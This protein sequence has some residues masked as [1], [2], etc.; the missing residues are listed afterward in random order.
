MAFSFALLVEG[1]LVALLVIADASSSLVS[2]DE[3]PPREIPI[4]VT[5]VIE[6]MPLLKLG[7]KKRENALP[8]MWRK[9]TPKKRYE[10]KSAASTKAAKE[11][12][13]LPESEMARSDES[14]APED[15]E[16]AKKVDEDIIEEEPTEDPNYAEEG[17][18]DGVIGGTETDALK[19]FVIDQYK[20]T[21]IAWFKAGFSAPAG[22]EYCELV[23]AASATVAADRTVTSFAIRAGSGNE[24]LDAKAKAHLQS[25]VGKKLPPPP[26]QYPELGEFIYFPRISGKNSSCNNKS[27]KKDK[28]ATEPSAPDESPDEA[29]APREPSP[30][31]PDFGSDSDGIL[32]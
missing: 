28:V 8:D 4:A 30:A 14:P 32:E 12:D 15:A 5:P 17:E 23:V 22:A 10:D 24:T 1:A 29:P 13:V 9:P 7:S 3:S 16:L 2:K 11:L 27:A 20:A 18:A 21:I 31:P 6:D 26:P 25:K 19:A